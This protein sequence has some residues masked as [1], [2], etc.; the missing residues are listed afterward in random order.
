MPTNERTVLFG[1]LLGSSIFFSSIDFNLKGK[2][3]KTS[4]NRE[5][6]VH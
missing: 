3:R 6:T 5:R 1:A 2:F 4:K